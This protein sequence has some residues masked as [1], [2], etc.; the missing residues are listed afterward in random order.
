MVFALAQR[1][2]RWALRLPQGATV[3]DALQAATLGEAG[4]SADA[5]PAGV[6]IFGRQVGLDA[7]LQPGDR[8]EIY[9]V[10]LHDP[11]EERR[12]RVERERAAQ[13]PASRR[14]S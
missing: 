7:A 13:R 4:L 8:V 10:L 9:R 1:C 3:A 6:G 11:R 2:W 5:L 12:L 14:G